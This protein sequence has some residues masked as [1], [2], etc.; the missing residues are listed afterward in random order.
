MSAAPPL[1]SVEDLWVRFHTRKGLV[2]AVRGISL[3]VGREKLGIVG[4]SGSGKT[5]TG[6]AILKLIRPPG[7]VAATR[8]DFSGVDLLAASEVDMRRIRG[9]RSERSRNP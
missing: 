6:R 8:M 3:S 2:E 1:L 5:M 7:E 9:E 4:E